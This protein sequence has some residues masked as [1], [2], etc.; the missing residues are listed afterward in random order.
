MSTRP[1]RRVLLDAAFEYAEHHWAVFPLRGKVPAIPNPHPQGSPER[2]NCKGECG[3]PGHGVL[4]A[5]TV[6]DQI[7][8]WW[9]GRYAG[10][11]IGC[12]VPTSMF[13]LDVDPRHG[14][15]ESLAALT[16]TYGPP[17]DT[18]TTYSGRGDGGR[19]LFFRRPPGA[20]SAR[21]LGPGMDIKTSSG[22]TVQAP[23][24][25]H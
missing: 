2:Q 3:R 7:L 14:G 24:A 17:P 21:R 25:R 1:S 5:T 20:L 12:R 19:H 10:C 16:A 4:D 9:G 13:V 18:L 22:Y 6:T 11:N 8:D 15:L 23:V